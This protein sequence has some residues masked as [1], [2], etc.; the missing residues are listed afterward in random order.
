MSDKKDL[1]NVTP[2]EAERAL[3]QAVPIRKF[4]ADSIGSFTVNWV[5]NPTIDIDDFPA[6]VAGKKVYGWGKTMS[7]I[8]GGIYQG[9]LIGV[10]AQGAGM[11]KTSFLQQLV[12]AIAL[13]N[14][15]VLDAGNKEEPL[16]PIIVLSELDRYELKLRTVGRY[17]KLPYSAIRSKRRAI[18]VLKLTEEGAE[19]LRQSVERFAREEKLQERMTPWVH[20]LDPKDRTQFRETLES[21]LHILKQETEQKYPG[22][23]VW[24]MVVLDPLQ[25]WVASEGDTVMGAGSLAI[26]IR[27]LCRRNGYIGVFTSDTNKSVATQNKDGLTLDEAQAKVGVDSFRGSQE[28]LHA[29]TT[30][31]VLYRIRDDNNNPHNLERQ[32]YAH[33]VKN[34]DGLDRVGVSYLWHRPSGSFVEM[35][36]KDLINFKD[37]QSTIDPLK[38]MRMDMI[39][40]I[41]GDTEDNVIDV[42]TVLHGIPPGDKDG[43]NQ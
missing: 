43:K 9:C 7:D 22:Y 39:K 32:M 27:N 24:P 6:Y 13:R 21:D 8:I 18:R 1:A 28:I 36:V 17:M 14:S 12:D 5:D 23:K 25:R 16:I 35:T 34:R 11:G 10:S 2:E 15:A 19:E 31:I 4:Q 40:A 20:I 38:K 37:D 3:L 41:N 30:A 42:T 26:W 29:C 33:I